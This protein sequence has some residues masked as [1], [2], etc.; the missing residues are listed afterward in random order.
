MGNARDS[1]PDFNAGGVGLRLACPNGLWCSVVPGGKGKSEVEPD[2]G[3]RVALDGAKTLAAAALSETESGKSGVEMFGIWGG[4]EFKLP[5][6]FVGSAKL[7]VLPAEGNASG[8]TLGLEGAGAKSCGGIDACSP[9]LGFFR[10][11]D[12]RSGV[13]ACSY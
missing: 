3:S 4:G 7:L 6:V 10:A 5:A 11:V 2:C 13:P 8:W 9:M 1:D 12:S